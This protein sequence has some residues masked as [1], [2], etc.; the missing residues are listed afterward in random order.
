GYSP[1]VDG[2]K[3]TDENFGGINWQAER[4]KLVAEL[5]KVLMAEWPSISS[6][7]QARV[8]AGLT[9][10]ADW[11]GSGKFFEDPA[12]PW[13][14]NIAKALDEAGFV[15]PAYNQSLGFADVFGFNPR[16]EQSAFIDL[17]KGPGVYVLEAPMGI[18]KTE[19]ALF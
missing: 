18:G 9:S 17:V 4:E 12:L 7:S 10:V 11:I 15:Q 1:G 16:A 3:A 5:K 19:A 13:Q 2:R 14:E 6:V 8:I